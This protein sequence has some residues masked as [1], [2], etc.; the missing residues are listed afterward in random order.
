MSLPPTF[1]HKILSW[2]EHWETV[3]IICQGLS[4]QDANVLVSLHPKMDMQNY[5]HLEQ[6]YSL[7]IA[8]QPLREVLAIAD[9]FV[10]SQG[11]STLLWAILCNIPTIVCDWYGLNYKQDY[12]MGMM[13]VVRNVENFET[14]L[15]TN[16]SKSNH[17]FKVAE[18]ESYDK[19]VVFDGK[20]MDRIIEAIQIYSR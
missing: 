10:A 20:A 18:L 1:E 19:K 6:D 12:W 5:Q 17:Q 16:L 9:V 2:E 15:S 13:D 14:T 8:T 7:K 11:S 4:E 3:N